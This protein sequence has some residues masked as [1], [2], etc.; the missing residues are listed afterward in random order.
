MR[1][2]AFRGRS[3]K[4]I[5]ILWHDRHVALCQ[6]AGARKVHLA[7]S[8]DP[9]GVDLDRTPAVYAGW[10]NEEFPSTGEPSLRAGWTGRIQQH[11]RSET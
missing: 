8:V 1:A 6:T 11:D 3:C 7:P 9:R 10:I 4:L 5:K 2:A